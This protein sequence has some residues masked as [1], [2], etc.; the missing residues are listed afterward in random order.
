[1][2]NVGKTVAR[3][4]TA[5]GTLGISEATGIGRMI[6]SKPPIPSA[7][8]ANEAAAKSK[9][10]PMTAQ[11]KQELAEQEFN[12]QRKARGFTTLLTSRGQRGALFSTLTR[13]L[14]AGSGSK[15]TLG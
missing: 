4:A 2:G 12:K 15:D 13:P 8:S 6:S 10:E 7:G 9:I 1:M 3:I 11:Q 5:V 14:Q